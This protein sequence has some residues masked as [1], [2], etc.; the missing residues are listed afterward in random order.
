MK[1]YVEITL[2]PDA[3]TPLCFLWEKLYQQVHLAFVEVADAESRIQVGVSFPQYDQ[4]KR[5]L[6]AKLR[7]FAESEQALAQLQLAK[8]LARLSDYVHVKGVQDVPT[9]VDG[10]AFFKRLNDKSNKARLAR[11]RAKRLN[12]PFDV[13]LAY[14][15]NQDEETR[16]A[17]KKQVSSYPFI[18]MTSLSSG[19]KYPVTIVR[20]AVDSLVW[21]EGF[22]TYGLSVDR[23]A[24]KQT[25][26]TMLR[27]DSS[28][29]LF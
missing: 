8:W 5:R 23:D 13:A 17:P 16:I 9:R 3:E 24:S 14:F 18:S 20:E 4:E 25:T 12:V 29:P 1:K 10:Y 2:L 7:L 6:G 27:K 19:S 21:G 15:T 26:D 11:R 22:N 28:V